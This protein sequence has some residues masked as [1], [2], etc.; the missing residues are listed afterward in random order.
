MVTHEYMQ[1]MCR[2]LATS[3][4]L[5]DR[6]FVV[7]APYASANEDHAA[8]RSHLAHCMLLTKKNERVRSPDP[9]G[10]TRRL[11]YRIAT[12][13]RASARIKVTNKPVK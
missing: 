7:H 11:R 12:V 5:V 1:S 2:L 4:T 13:G 3:G 9:L 10:V 6:G 8:I